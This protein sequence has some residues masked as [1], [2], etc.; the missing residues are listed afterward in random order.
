VADVI[1]RNH[2]IAAI[3]GFAAHDDVDVGIVGIPVIDSDPIEP[4]AEVPLCLRH[5]VPSKRL[6]IR[7]ALRVLGRHDKPEMMSIAFAAAG[8]RAVVGVIALGV[9][10]PAG[11]AVL[12]HPLSPQVGQVRAERRSP[13]PVT[14]YAR[15]HNDAA[16]PVRHQP[17]GRDTCR[18]ATAESAAPGAASRSPVQTAGLLGGRQRP[19]NERLC[20]AGAAVSPIPDAAD[21]DA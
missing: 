15:L 2:E 11:G 21:S 12:G 20:P 1:A 9:E 6:E 5:Q 10:H 7:E 4:G 13:R 14:H 17:G 8:E 18:P 16:R 19:R 3:I